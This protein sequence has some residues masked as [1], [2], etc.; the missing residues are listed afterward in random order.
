MDIQPPEKP[1]IVAQLDPQVKRDLE[2]LRSKRFERALIKKPLI[3]TNGPFKSMSLEFDWTDLG[4]WPKPAKDFRDKSHGGNRYRHHDYRLIESRC[5]LRIPNDY[6]FTND[7]LS[8]TMR[9]LVSQTT[10]PVQKSEWDNIAVFGMSANPKFFTIESV[11]VIELADKRVI[12]MTGTNKESG[13]REKSF[14]LSLAGDWKEYYEFC[15]GGSPDKATFESQLA[16]LDKA[17]KTI[18]WKSK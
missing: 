18:V 2:E 15:V 16:K 7:E 9:R 10:G 8:K 6:K 14:Y 1:P 11:E 13:T 4:I 5:T 3:V 12:T 17:L